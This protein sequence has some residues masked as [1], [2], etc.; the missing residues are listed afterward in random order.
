MQTTATMNLPPPPVE[1]S[2]RFHDDVA[3]RVGLLRG[4]AFFAAAVF[5]G[6]V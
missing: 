3:Y 5:V 6:G 4:A 1:S 2:E